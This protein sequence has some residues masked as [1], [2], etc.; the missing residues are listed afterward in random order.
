MFRSFLRR[1][2]RLEQPARDEATCQVVIEARAR[3]GRKVDKLIAWLRRGDPLDS[4]GSPVPDALA[5]PS[6]ARDR[7][8]ARLDKIHDSHRRDFDPDAET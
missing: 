2:E 5:G 7:L 3:V 1:V 4:F 8:M 6:P